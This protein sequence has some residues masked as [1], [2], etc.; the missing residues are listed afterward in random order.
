M[1]NKQ[2]IPQ[3]IG[4]FTPITH[5]Q[6]FMRK[7]KFSF[8]FS[9]FHPTQGSKDTKTQGGVNEC[10]RIRKTRN[11]IKEREQSKSNQEDSR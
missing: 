11:I 5:C 4:T 8:L 2:H 10:E 1:K 6:K 3:N 7:L 9:S